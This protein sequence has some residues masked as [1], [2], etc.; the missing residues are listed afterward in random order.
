MTMNNNSSSEGI[1]LNKADKILLL[2]IARKGYIG[3]KER[4]EL[5]QLL[6]AKSLTLRVISTRAELDELRRLDELRKQF[7]IDGDSGVPIEKDALYIAI[8]K[9]IEDYR[10]ELKGK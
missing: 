8:Q 6:K 2:T 7:N 4:C 1:L 5:Q 9:E 3:D 10:N